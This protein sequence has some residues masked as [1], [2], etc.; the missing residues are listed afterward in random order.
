MKKIIP[1]KRGDTFKRRNTYMLE[2]DGVRTPIDITGYTIRAHIRSVDTLI[3]SLTVNIIDAVNGVYE[4]VAEKE[5]TELWPT[6]IF[7]MDIEFTIGGFRK[8]TEDIIIEV[9]KD[10]T[11]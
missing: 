5:Q 2:V 6:G 11:R 8:S 3:Q 9:L 7:K 4:L 10:Q 1:F